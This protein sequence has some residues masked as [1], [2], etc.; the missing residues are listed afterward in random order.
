MLHQSWLIKWLS[1]LLI[2]L[3]GLASYANPVTQTVDQIIKPYQIKK[4]LP[5]IALAI[6]YH[7]QDYLLNYGYANI[8]NHTKVSSHTIFSLASI[9]KVFTTTL[10]AYEVVIGRLKLDDP[11]I[12]Y[13]PALKGSH[14]LAIDKVSLLDLATHTASFPR[15]VQDLGAIKGNNHSLIEQLK[16][17]Q[18]AYTIGSAYLYSNVSF[19]LL[20]QVIADAL[21][22][23]YMSLLD[24]IILKPLAMH[25]TYVN[26]PK[27]DQ[28]L[29][30]QGYTPT[31][32]L[33]PY[34]MASQLLGGGALRSSA[35]DMLQF[36]KANL[37]IAV[38]SAS[39]PLLNAMQLAQIPRYRV[40][41]R[42]LQGLGWQ[43]ITFVD[44]R[45]YITKNGQLPGFSTYIGFSKAQQMGVVVLIN[46]TNAQAA[47]LGQRILL[48]LARASGS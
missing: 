48:A 5:G 42:F 46:Q 19:G 44:G 13:I 43:Q 27:G 30:A 45:A 10:L 21:H 26:T 36:L 28:P 40:K 32:A 24:R 15:D 1:M 39:Q 23:D 16:R 29:L 18:P 12:R 9:T 38:G 3:C 33:A 22:D 37:G 20:G 14:G 4:S 11:I 41:P 47:V 34:F 6:H 25:H 8:A 31:H 35:F 2:S 7:G 17:W